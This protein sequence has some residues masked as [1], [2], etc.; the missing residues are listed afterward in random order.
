MIIMSNLFH[1]LSHQDEII[2]N[3]IYFGSISWFCFISFHS[4]IHLIKYGVNYRD[5]ESIKLSKIIKTEKSPPK[6]AE[7]TILHLINMF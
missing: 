2:Y 7:R 1:L 6:L 3:F 4:N 5:I